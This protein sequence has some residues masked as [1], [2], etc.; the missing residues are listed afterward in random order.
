MKNLFII[1]ILVS[2]VACK[3]NQPDNK[4]GVVTAAPVIPPPCLEDSITEE[5]DGRESVLVIGDSISMNYTPEVKNE[6]PEHQV[7][8]TKCNNRNSNYGVLHIQNWLDNNNHWNVCTINHGIHDTFYGTNT[9]V[10]TYKENLRFEI[11]AMKLKCDKI[12]FVNTTI[13]DNEQANEEIENFN[14]AAEE[15]MGELEVSVCDLHTTSKSV[16]H[17]RW[18]N[19]EVHFNAEGSKVLAH[20]LSSCIKGE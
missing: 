12:I 13:T 5:I 6:L 15:L 4:P 10:E 8:H 9:P 16:S 19:D 18:L 3:S 2:C 7:V 14:N 20:K 1:L 11:E 17:K